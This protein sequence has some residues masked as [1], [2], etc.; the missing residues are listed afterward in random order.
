MVSVF[1]IFSGWIEWS[2]QIYYLNC[3]IISLLS[4]L[5]GIVL[6]GTEMLHV[7]K[8]LGIT[9]WFTWKNIL[10][11]FGRL[12]EWKK[13]KWNNY[14]FFIHICMYRMQMSHK[15]N[16]VSIMFKISC[17]GLFWVFIIILYLF[18]NTS[19]SCFPLMPSKEANSG[20]S[21]NPPPSRSS[22]TITYQGPLTLKMAETRPP[23]YSPHI[24]K[25]LTLPP[26]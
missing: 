7:K 20:K 10:N 12:L 25:V 11:N 9:C 3:P 1:N 13:L 18:S 17:C 26:K 22:V 19:L 15:N 24:C 2:Q 5:G 8:H 23:K 16:F 4:L 14:E 21:S 6:T